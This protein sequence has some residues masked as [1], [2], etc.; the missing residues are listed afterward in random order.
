VFLY[1]A[2]LRSV[3]EMWCDL[4]FVT[5]SLCYK[6]NAMALRGKRVYCATSSQFYLVAVN[7]NRKTRTAGTNKGSQ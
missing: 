1:F 4:A 7:A 5:G 3:N 2:I 6:K